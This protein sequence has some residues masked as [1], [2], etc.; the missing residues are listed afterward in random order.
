MPDNSPMKLLMNLAE[1]FEP[2][3]K[4]L[5]EP[6]I[7]TP[8]QVLEYALQSIVVLDIIKSDEL[9]NLIFNAITK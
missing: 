1:L 3:V 5:K 2:A 6:M 7:Y 4:L 8:E 9:I